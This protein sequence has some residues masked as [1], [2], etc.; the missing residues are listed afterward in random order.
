MILWRTHKTSYFHPKHFWLPL[1]IFFNRKNFNVLVDRR[2]RVVRNSS[3]LR[4]CI[5]MLR[6]VWKPR[7][8]RRLSIPAKDLPSA[9]WCKRTS[10]FTSTE[11]CREPDTTINPRSSSSANGFLVAELRF[12][13]KRLWNYSTVNWWRINPL[14]IHECSEMRPCLKRRISVPLRI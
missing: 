5:R 4:R 13:R 7:C 10:N 6:F 8:C 9:V 1:Q 3:E 14:A 2:A 12:Q 11:S